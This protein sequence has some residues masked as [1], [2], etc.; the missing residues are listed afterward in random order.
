[1]STRSP[2]SNLACALLLLTM[3]AWPPS[4]TRAMQDDTP[5]PAGEPAA[6]PAEE[7]KTPP[8]P[9]VVTERRLPDGVRVLTQP[10]DG[11]SH[12][13]IIA[14]LEVG[15]ANDPVDGPGLSRLFDR[16][17]M[18]CP[19]QDLPARR[20]NDLDEAY[21][22]GWNIRSYDRMGVYGIVVP[23]ERVGDEVEQLARRLRTLQI[24]ADD[25]ARETGSIEAE[26]K[27]LFDDR[28][29]GKP[30]SWLVAKAFRHDSGA[31]RGI[32]PVRLARLS[33][34]RLMLEWQKRI[35]GGNVTLI[36]VG[37]VSRIGLDAITDK[38]FGALAS[39][40]RPDFPITV[41]PVGQV[42]RDIM[43]SS[44]LPGNRHHGTAA[45]YA[46]PVTSPDHPGFLVI[47]NALMRDAAGMAGAAARLEIQYDMLLDPR[48][49]YLTP[50]AWRYPKGP[51][52]ALGYWDAKIKN[53]K[54][55]HADA[56]RTLGALDWQLGAPL[57]GGVVDQLAHQPSLLYTIGYATVY[58]AAYGDTAFW[59]NYRRQLERMDTKTLDAVRQ[60][61]FADANRALF[62][63][64]GD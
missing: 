53:R 61:Y 64:K 6:E 56:V 21:P 26:M 43:D 18:T 35:V 3:F 4:S 60:K 59:D 16:L 50:Q 36:L 42:V 44:G 51:A 48:A 49:V 7:S 31:A 28:P 15:S 10:I 38:A 32:D 8:A 27:V 30:M 54:Y 57:R 5:P 62:I 11:V 19:A 22:L 29:L 34:D 55:T 14:V 58:R 17:L 63:L 25:I 23:S 33:A 52:Q 45:F 41:H 20:V 1:M 46:P 2:F 37:D 9:Q 39:G 13:A 12:A 47:S 40:E 24:T